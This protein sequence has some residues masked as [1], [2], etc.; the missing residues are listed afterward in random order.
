MLRTQAENDD[1]R[2]E[3]EVQTIQQS[4]QV[5]VHK[6]KW[7]DMVKGTNLR[8][9]MLV[10]VAYTY[11][12]ITGQAFTSTYQVVF[13]RQNGYAAQAF[14][15]P[16]IGSVLAMAAV[17]PGMVLV[18]SLGRRPV[19]LI[20]NAGQMLFLFLLGGLGSKQGRSTTENGALVA[21]FMLFSVSYCVGHSL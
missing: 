12:Q 1:G 7:I 14:T 18:D 9:T 21:F 6:G 16:I 19:L 17:L 10:M 8:R 20:S 5:R 2:S 3:A 11:Q 4:L 13:Y 15:Y